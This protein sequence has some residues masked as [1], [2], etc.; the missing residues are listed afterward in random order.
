MK[1]AFCVILLYGYVVAHAHEVRPAYLEITENADHSLSVTWK[2]PV[3]G[4]YAVPLDP[5]ITTGWFQDDH[6]EKVF[7]PS[8]LIKQWMIPPAHSS[9]NEQTISIRG[10]EKTMTDVLIQISLLKGSFIYLVKPVHPFVK[11]DISKP[12]PPP[13]WQYIELGVHH[14][15]SGL[16]HLLF[17]FGLILLVAKRSSLLWTITAFTIAHSITLAL[18]TL[19]ILQVSPA[20]T[21]PAIALSIAFVGVELVRHYQNKNGLAFKFPWLVAFLFGLLHGLGFAGALRDVGL[22][23]DNIP[24]ALFLFNVGVELGQLTFVT[25]VLLL[26]AIIKRL[27]FQFPKWS[28]KIPPYMIGTMA[29][30]WFIER[31]ALL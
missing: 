7:S 20:F 25:V 8:Y 23:Q 30:Y 5:V 10:L 17:V 3:I 22:P 16:D 29:M 1:Q 28:Y 4:E 27:S 26:I 31:L 18:A 21:E 15:W 14:I 11:L 13:V 19:R 2:Q 12:Q 24:T 9:L 6:A